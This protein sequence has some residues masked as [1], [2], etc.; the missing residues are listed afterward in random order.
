MERS[1]YCRVFAYFFFVP[2]FWFCAIVLLTLLGAYLSLLE[3]SEVI[4]AYSKS[5]Q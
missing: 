2:F 1:R 3:A 4:Q 5:R